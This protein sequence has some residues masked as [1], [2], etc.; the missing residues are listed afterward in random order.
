MQRVS[1]P[2]NT[3]RAEPSQGFWVTTARRRIE[4]EDG[5]LTPADVQGIRARP[6]PD[7]PRP[8]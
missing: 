6:S 1:L 5:D 3:V 2:G 8:L 4:P 7:S